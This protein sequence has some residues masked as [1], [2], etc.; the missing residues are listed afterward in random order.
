MAEDRENTDKHSNVV[1][2]E[3]TKPKNAFDRL[4]GYSGQE[5]DRRR[6]A[7]QGQADVAASAP[8]EKGIANPP[9]PEDPDSFG[10]DQ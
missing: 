3:R 8:R 2:P 7:L 1:D 6:E 9:P 4:G 5:Y 10:A